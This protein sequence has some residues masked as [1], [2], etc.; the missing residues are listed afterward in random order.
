MPRANQYRK[1]N[2]PLEAANVQRPSAQSKEFQ[3]VF[4][5]RP[6]NRE[7]TR[8]LQNLAGYAQGKH[9]EQVAEAQKEF[10][11]SL[12]AAAER[13]F[14]SGTENTE[15]LEGQAIYRDALR[16]LQGDNAG[17]V[18][19]AKLKE[20][21]VAA[22]TKDPAGF[23][24]QAFAQER[25]AEFAQSPEFQDA[26][27]SG[28]ATKQITML[29]KEL[30]EIGVRASANAALQEGEDTAIQSAYTMFR[31]GTWDPKLYA[32]QTEGIGLEPNDRTKAMISGAISAMDQAESLKDLEAFKPLMEN[33]SEAQRAHHGDEL[34]RAFRTAENRLKVDDAKGKNARTVEDMRA[35]RELKEA[36]MNDQLGHG[37]LQEA[38]D[39]ALITSGE[40]ETLVNQRWDAD[41]KAH[42]AE[43]RNQE[44]LATLEAGPEALAARDPDYVKDFKDWYDTQSQEVGREVM[45]LAHDIRT[46]KDPEGAR[47]ALNQHLSNVA[48]DITQ[49]QLMGIRPGWIKSY[50]SGAAD[51]SSPA[52]ETL[53]IVSQQLQE[54]FGTGILADVPS[55]TVASLNAY[56][57]YRSMGLE[58]KDASERMT[59][60]GEA[61]AAES[62]AKLQKQD[63]FKK[64]VAVN[65]DEVDPD[66]FLE[67][68]SEFYRVN[69]DV[70]W[71]LTQAKSRWDETRVMVD[72]KPWDA[73]V[74]PPGFAQV[75]EAG[76]DTLRERFVEAKR[77]GEDEDFRL[78]P[79]GGPS[80]RFWMINTTTG[81]PL[82]NDDGS[83][84]Y[85]SAGELQAYMGKLDAIAA[86][87]AE[88]ADAAKAADITRKA[89]E[90]EERHEAYLQTASP[91]LIP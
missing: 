44:H 58:A 23:D 55:S 38:V 80:G 74:I 86:D 46:G 69:S 62:R 33:L 8:F 59:T 26:A 35:R 77:I 17:F 2:K 31:T 45:A 37:A 79:V 25:L 4:M 67:I 51:P 66:A 18:F 1:D 91:S 75:Y 81:D 71:A 84:S 57:H 12:V 21:A 6:G 54:K 60:L 16:N 76:K 68:A 78:V 42:A 14:A 87:E 53:S 43:L 85:W 61:S 39:N 27:Y 63:A 20:E 29:Q 32:Q 47:A 65:G 15:L 40:M 30:Q 56:A 10:D 89:G 3:R 5:S 50:M 7:T 82:Y 13:D 36:F 88:A 64:W 24:P 34:S 72:G 49:A 90:Y 11:A 9:K 73:R 48:G 22:A 19:R 41:E 83:R 28:A 70:E 52:M